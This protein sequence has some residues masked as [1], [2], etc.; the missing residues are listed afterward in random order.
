MILYNEMGMRGLIFH[1]SDY[2]NHCLLECDTMQSVRC[3][4]KYITVIM[5][6]QVPLKCH[7]TYIRVYDISQYMTSHP[8]GKKWWINWED[9]EA[10]TCGLF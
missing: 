5:R 4:D 1:V 2:E 10:Y 7:Y 9:D 6:E 8:K 3:V